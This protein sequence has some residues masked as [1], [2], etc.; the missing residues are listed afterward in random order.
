MPVRGPA[1]AVM[2]AL[3]CAIAFGPTGASARGGAGVG[4]VRGGPGF[5]RGGP[6]F[7][8]GVVHPRAFVRF[9]QVV[10]ARRDFGRRHFHNPEPNAGEV[11]GPA[12]VLLPGDAPPEGEKVYHA[13]LPPW[14]D[15]FAQPQFVPSAT[16]AGV[17]RVVVTRCWR[18]N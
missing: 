3:V 2:A 6:A 18:R 14:R 5:A 4:F 8:R 15:C 16:H 9:H 11:F 1:R 17:A 12:M 10:R 7:A 13:G